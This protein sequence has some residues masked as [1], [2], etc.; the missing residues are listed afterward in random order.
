[1]GGEPSV[2]S[3]SVHGPHHTTFRP[4]DNAG[5]TSPPRGGP[6]SHYAA[7][8]ESSGFLTLRC[9]GFADARGTIPGANAAI[10]Q[11][12]TQTTA[13]DTFDVLAI[14]PE[15]ELAGHPL[16]A[17][18][19]ALHLPGHVVAPAL[20]NA[21]TH[22]DLTHIG[23]RP[24]GPGGFAAWID[25]VRRERRTDDPG[26]E[27]SVREGID[28]LRRGGT[29]AVGDIAGSVAGAPSLVPA[30]LLD[31]AGIGGV[32]YLEFFALSPDGSPG[33]D[34]ALVQAAAFSPKTMRLGLEPHAPYSA[35]IGA[36]QRAKAS[37]L[38]I[39]THLA[40]SA[41]ERD[42]VAHARGPIR[43][44]LEG[45][46]LWN[47]TLDG[48][49][50]QGRSPVEHLAGLLGGVLVVHAND[51][52]DEDID[53]LAREGARVVYCPRAS[54]YFDA[55]SAFGPHR[56]RDLLNAGVPVAL[57]TDS[58]VNLPSS[59]VQTRGICVLDEARH[60]H[61]RDGAAPGLLLEMLYVHTPLVLG[62]PAGGYR[63]EAGTTVGGLLAV[64]ADGPDAAA[65]L[66]ASRGPIML[67]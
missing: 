3:G 36:Y 26:I 25:M 10:V 41:A 7:R 52:R 24:I 38:P 17:H 48:M 23:P 31:G 44:M 14:G 2:L 11:R 5:P 67:L 13:T 9:A 57:G 53:R 42:L 1:M 34:R 33:F 60:L 56:Y 30:R 6:A 16:W 58:V 22:L 40:E 50:G 39:C 59:D 28:R 61:D 64:E 18:T 37:G 21:H 62:L 46:G 63:L 27:A 20:A 32:S 49:F 43:S 29:V 66:V 15:H 4:D 35:S 19:P 45:L 55:P 65:G 47:A 51:L 8:G 12:R 54:D